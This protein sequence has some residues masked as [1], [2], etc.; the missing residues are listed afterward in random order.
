MISDCK[1]SEYLPYSNKSH[2][3]ASCIF[4][5]DTK[6]YSLNLTDDVIYAMLFLSMV[7]YCFNKN[8]NGM[9]ILLS[10][11][12]Y[13]KIKVSGWEVIF[14]QCGPSR[15]NIILLYVHAS[16]NNAALITRWMLDDLVNESGIAMYSYQC[17]D[18]TDDTLIL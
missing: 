16:L 5:C 6:Q 10:E 4:I 8:K 7:K 9:Y 12:V 3:Y 13:L 14:A 2:Y 11:D 17:L 18:N 15:N 1:I